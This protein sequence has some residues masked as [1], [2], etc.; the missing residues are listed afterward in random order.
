MQRDDTATGQGIT[1]KPHIALVVKK[2]RPSGGAEQM[3]NL[4]LKV[5]RSF[6]VHLS[7]LACDLEGAPDGFEFYHLKP[8]HFGRLGR[9]SGFARAAQ[10]VLDKLQPDLVLSQEHIGGCGVY[11]AGGGVK[12]EWYAQ[13]RR[14]HGPFQRLWKHL[15][16][17]DRSVLPLE[18]A[19]YES[20]DLRAVICNSAMVRDDILHHFDVTADKLRV[21]ENALDIEHYR[22][23]DD[24]ATRAQFLRNKL[25]VPAKCP[26]WLFVGS[27][28]E[29]K[30]LGSAIAALAHAD[31]HGHLV[32]VGRDH[33]LRQYRRY[34][35]RLGIGRRVH[36][37]GNQT[38]VRPYYWA[39]DGLLHPALYEAY[40]LVVLEA[41]AA[42]LPV[43]SSV[44]CGAANALI[45]KGEN[46]FI[47]DALDIPALAESIRRIEM[48]SDYQAFAQAAY[49]AAKP[50]DL[51]RLRTDVQ[52]LCEELL[53]RMS[54]G[55]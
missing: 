53:A 6:D 40:G 48:T 26:M 31:S 14:L 25:G 41:M 16:I 29:R 32:V 52:A 27:G 15:D 47:H 37:V 17:A 5:L 23:P 24:A 46:G 20:R 7:V 3:G 50:N 19:T 43:V 1:Q 39:A 30:G 36:F 34:A 38:D 9:A 55:S 54:P 2:L 49:M 11:R 21:I 18:Q 42:G 22:R 8:T 33:R 28:F 12:A 44:Q 45:Q 10:Q 35:A 4:L 13:R 51:A